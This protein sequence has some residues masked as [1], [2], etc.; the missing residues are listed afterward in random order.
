MIVATKGVA[1]WAT[2]KFCSRTLRQRDR[3]VA[4]PAPP[5]SIAA[6]QHAGGGHAAS[7]TRAACRAAA[8]VGR[9]GSRPPGCMP[10]SR[11]SCGSCGSCA[12][13]CVCGSCGSRPHESR[14]IQLAATLRRRVFAWAIVWAVWGSSRGS[15]FL[16]VVGHVG[17]AHAAHP[18][19]STNSCIYNHCF[20]GLHN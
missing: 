11:G 1:A 20:L 15:S 17:H 5:L 13:M 4:G 8:A 2:K 10:V 6:L 3:P 19:Y 9:R 7:P 18:I 16:G 14:S 12:R